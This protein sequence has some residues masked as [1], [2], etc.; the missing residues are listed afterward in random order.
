MEHATG[1]RGGIDLGGTKIQAVV[2]GGDHSVLGQARR[3]TPTTGGPPAVTAAMADAMRDAARDAG[4]EPATL[5]GIGVGSPGA[6]DSEAGTVAHAGNLPDWDAPFAVSSTLTAA[7]GAPVSLANDVDA[8]TLAEY[9]L[10]AGAPYKDLL[11]VFWGTGVGSG[12]IL[13]GER[14]DGRGS[15]GELGHMVVRLNG[16]LCPCG[17]RGCVEAYAGRGAMELHARRLVDEEGRHTRLFKIMERR[18]KPRLSSGVWQEA[19]ESDDRM[20]HELIER[21][22]AALAA[23]VASAINLLDVE[24]V[25]V[26]GGLGTR[27]GQPYADRLLEAMRPHLFVDERPPV[28]LAA[29][30]GDLGGAIGATLIL[31]AH[32]PVAPSAAPPS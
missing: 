20:A 7:L 10:G 1:L 27:F 2:V 26:G 11:G 5:T 9:E 21:A 32:D 14:W 15:A 16:A 4:V 19:L 23:G 13:H 17:R 29:S 28:V 22:L 25:V 8:A 3:P 30:L 12:I 18:G 31:P 24:A 6:I